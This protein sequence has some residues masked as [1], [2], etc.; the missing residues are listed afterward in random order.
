MTYKSIKKQFSRIFN[1]SV[2]FIG[3]TEPDLESTF[4][5]IVDTGFRN[6]TYMKGKSIIKILSNPQMVH[7]LQKQN[8]TFDKRII[9]S[10]KNRGIHKKY[11]FLMYISININERTK[12]H[13]ENVSKGI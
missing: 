13:I 7:Y 1:A 8:C 4:N 9:D 5:F 12:I 6:R 11:T 10:I 2:K 3:T